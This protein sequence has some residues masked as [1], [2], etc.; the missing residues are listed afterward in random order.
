MRAPEPESPTMPT[1]LRHLAACLLLG[2]AA[3]LPARAT[4]VTV[5]YSDLWWVGPAEDGWG[6]NVI[7]QGEII[8]A[9]FFVYGPDKTPRWYAA[10][11][12][13]IGGAQPSNGHRFAGDLYETTGPWFG[14][15]WDPAQAS[16]QVVGTASL[17]FTSPDIATLT[18][19]VNGTAVLKAIVRQTFRANSVAGQY[20]GGLV[21]IASNCRTASDNGRVDIL[22]S[23]TATH[24]GNNVAFQVDFVAGSGFSATCLFSGT[25]QPRGRLGN[26]AAGNFSCVVGGQ[27]A[28]SGTFTMTAV[29][30]QRNGF[31]AAFSGADQFCTY[32]GRFGG[33]REA[34]T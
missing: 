21:A 19:T 26:V 23:V 33:T 20:A 27:Q 6:M 30:A 22:G 34:G 1:L 2:L 25:H 11:A 4:P 31:H 5:D 12:M 13:A 29:D 3:A 8:F 18:Y 24:S 16:G 10:P 32:N 28:N 15:P 14:G 17:S 7:Q 9:T